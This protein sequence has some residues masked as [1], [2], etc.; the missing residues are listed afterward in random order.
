[1]DKNLMSSKTEHVSIA[2]LLFKQ[3]L[4]FIFVDFLPI[5]IVANFSQIVNVDNSHR[6]TN[7]YT[8]QQIYLFVLF[9][10]RFVGLW[11]LFH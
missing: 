3:K 1:M 8:N 2:F 4:E 10:R 11:G 9:V 5:Y 7:L 6:S